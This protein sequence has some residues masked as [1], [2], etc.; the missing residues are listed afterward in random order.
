MLV[1][2]AMPQTAMAA[3]AAWDGKVDIEEQIPGFV[4]SNRLQISEYREDISY[5]MIEKME[6]QM[7]DAMTR[8]PI[9]A[10][11]RI[12]DLSGEEDGV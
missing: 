12:I 2:A 8:I 11:G 7:Q 4:L 3:A 6:R 10:F 5:E 9:G 1:T